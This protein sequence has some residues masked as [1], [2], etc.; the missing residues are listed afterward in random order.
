MNIS[1]EVLKKAKGRKRNEESE[2]R[3]NWVWWNCE[4]KAFSGTLVISGVV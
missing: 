2:N 1:V 4:T 3:Y